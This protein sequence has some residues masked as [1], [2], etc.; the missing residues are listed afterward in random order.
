MIEIE[1][2]IGGRQHRVSCADEDADRLHLLA[3]LVDNRI[4]EQTGG[5]SLSET[6]Q[7]LFAAL[8][9]ADE[10]EEAQRTAKTAPTP[11]LHQD[12]NPAESLANSSRMDVAMIDGLAERMEKLA[13]HLEQI[14]A[15]S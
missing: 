6:R 5:T 10:I 1:L 9:M 15:A 7:L 3:G 4:R 14:V 2:T 11:P 8:T 12:V 13:S